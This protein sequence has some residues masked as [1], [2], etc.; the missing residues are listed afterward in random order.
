MEDGSVTSVGQQDQLREREMLREETKEQGSEP[1]S[2][3]GWP[4][5]GAPPELAEPGAED[6]AN[7]NNDKEA[8]WR[9][10]DP[11]R[12]D[13]TAGQGLTGSGPSQPDD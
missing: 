11:D 13:R 10:G 12:P 3:D 7:E 1:V 8:G 6:K 9:P 4:A 5:G 2:P